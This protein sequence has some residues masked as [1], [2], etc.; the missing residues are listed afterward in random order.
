MSNLYRLDA[1]TT[2]LMHQ[3]GVVP[4]PELP[5]PS[6]VRPGERGLIVRGV[7]GERSMHVLKWGFPR[8]GRDVEPATVNLVADLTNFMWDGMVPDPRYRCLVPVSALGQP[9]GPKGSKTRTWFTIPEWPV[10]ALAGFCRTTPEWG[11]VYAAMTG[12]S[13][14]LVMPLNDRSPI[15]LAPA[16]Y[17]RWLTAPIEDVIA[18]QFRQPLPAERMAMERTDELW[19]PMSERSGRPRKQKDIRLV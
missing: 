5:V 17:D 18:F 13:N 15:I 16:E 14:E 3:F 7:S 2:E 19:V 8:P 1:S 6:P 9:D 11:P 4:A 12:D 10:F